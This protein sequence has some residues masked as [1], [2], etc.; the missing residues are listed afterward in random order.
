L[1][2]LETART[3]LIKRGGWSIL[4]SLISPPGV[5]I[6]LKY[7]SPIQGVRSIKKIIKERAITIFFSFLIIFL[8]IF[9]ERWPPLSILFILNKIKVVYKNNS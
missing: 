4:I 8:I 3:G 1:S 2:E 7:F 9:R 6:S 5:G